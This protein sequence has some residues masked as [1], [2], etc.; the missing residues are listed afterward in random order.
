ML[1]ELAREIMEWRQGHGFSTPDDLATEAN[2]DA[3]LGKLMLVVTEVAEAAEAVRHADMANF[4]EEIADACIRLFDIA[5]TCGIDLDAEI[6]GGTGKA[7]A[8]LARWG[9]SILCIEPGKNLAAVAARKL[10]DFS[11]VAFETVTFEDWQERPNEFDLVMSAQAFHWVP[12]EIGYAKAA[13]V[14]KENG[15]LALFWNMYLD[16]K[17]EIYSDLSQV[18]QECAP[19]L[20]GPSICWESLSKQREVGLIR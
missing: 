17:G 12:K 16:P 1:N 3:M 4:R 11:H 19:E 15:Y 10:K 18:Y 8:L 6:G 20:T 7:T 9:F 13:S 14:L 2:R 5:G